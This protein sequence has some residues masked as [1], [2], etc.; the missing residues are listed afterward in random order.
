M[1]LVIKKPVDL[2]SLGKEYEGISL[3][4][5]SIPAKDLGVLN[6]QQEELPRDDNGDPAL[7]DILPFF[8][9]ILEKYFIE[10]T[11]QDTKITK[12]DLSELDSEALTH[13]FQVITG[14]VIDPKAENSST[15]ISTTEASQA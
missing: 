5:R 11:Q 10:G 2:S 7:S 4:F 14:Q 1:A 15:N 12:E 8:I 9:N 3:V 6:K 13:C